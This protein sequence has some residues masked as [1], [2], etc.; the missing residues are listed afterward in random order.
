MNEQRRKETEGMNFP[1]VLI[2]ILNHFR[3]MFKIL[4]Q[5]ATH[6]IHS[7]EILV[8]ASKVYAKVTKCYYV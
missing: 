5:G 7:N 3:Q 6:S 2:L 4:L 8:L 1:V